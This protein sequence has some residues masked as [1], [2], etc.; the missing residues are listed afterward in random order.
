MTATQVAHSPIENA[1]NAPATRRRAWLRN[2]DA[3]TASRPVM[4]IQPARSEEEPVSR[5]RS[6]RRRPGGSTVS[7]WSASTT[8][9]NSA[10][11]AAVIRRARSSS[12]EPGSG[13]TPSQSGMKSATV[14]TGAPATPSAGRRTALRCRPSRTARS[15]RPVRRAITAQPILNG[16]VV[17][18]GPLTVPSGIWTK[19]PPLPTTARADATCWSIVTPPRHRQQAAHLVHKPL[20]AAPVNVDGALPRNHARGSTGRAC[21]TTNGSI[22]PRCAAP[23]SR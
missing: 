11:S 14:R 15:V 23:T 21:I 10:S 16:P 18:A 13:T 3:R 22:Q 8:G 2:T 1:R 17:P 20:A 19:T 5:L 4:P 6:Q 9:R 12:R 7:G